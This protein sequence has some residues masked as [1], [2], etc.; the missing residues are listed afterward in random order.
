MSKK[1]I[2]VALTAALVFAA[3]APIFGQQAVKVGVINSQKAFETSAEGKKTAVQLKDRDAKLKSDFAR[4]DS[5][6]QSLQAKLGAQRMTMSPEALLQLQNDIDKKTTARTR[7]QEDASRD[8]Q[9][10]Q[11]DI[12]Q[13]VRADMVSVVDAVAKEKGLDLVLDLGGSGIV[14]FNKALDI[15]DEVIKRYDESKAA[16]AKK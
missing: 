16:G 10:F 2:N 4:M 5:E 7:Y 1:R 13:R 12:V 8:I 6:L 3:A 15:T 14:Y 9:K 11:Y